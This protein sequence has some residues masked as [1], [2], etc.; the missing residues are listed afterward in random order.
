MS[1]TLARLLP[2]ASRTRLANPFDEQFQIIAAQG[3]LAAERLKSALSGSPEDALQEISVLEHKADDAVH[4]VHRLVDNTFIAPYDKRDIVNLAHRLDRVV[5]ALLSVAR[6]LVSYR[7]LEAAHA[8]ELKGKALAMCDL[9]VESVVQLKGVVDAMPS[10]E[11]DHLRKAARTVDNLEEQCDDL[12]MHAIRDLFPD[13][14]APLT[15]AMLAWRDIFRLLET[16][17]DYCS[18]AMGDL[19]SIARQEGH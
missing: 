6:S 16:C 10:F 13:P 2:F 19:L 8:D 4:S 1:K 14:N 12:F 18:H 7:A 15:T 5:D 3:A 11:H 17:T 9:I